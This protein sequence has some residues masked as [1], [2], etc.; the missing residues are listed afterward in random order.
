MR[1]LV[2]WFQHQVNN[3]Q[4]LILAAFLTIGFLLIVYAGKM[5]APVIAGMVVA[6]I[7]EGGVKKVQSLKVPRLGAV[8]IILSLFLLLLIALVF[9]IIPLVSSQSFQLAAQ[10]PSWLSDVQ[11]MLLQLPQIYPELLSEAQVR[12]F[13]RTTADYITE[14][15]Q[16]SVVS[17][18]SASV[19][20]FL[21]VV[22]YLIVVPILAFFFLK[23]KEKLTNWFVGILP[24]KNHDLAFT[25]WKNVDRQ[26]S[27]Y[28]RGKF[29]EILIVFFVTFITFS[30]FDLQFAAFLSVIVGLSV[31]IPI[32]GAAVVTLP[33]IV[34]AFG[35][36][37]IS[38]EFAYVVT[39]YIVIQILDG[40]VLVPLL[41]SQAVN[42]H[43]VAI[44]VALLVFGGWWGV[45]GVFFAIPLA[46]L[47]QSVM[48]AWP[49]MHDSALES[50]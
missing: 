33:V 7:L 3:P 25:V 31:L 48:T 28:I 11:K 44:V 43:P 16:Q 10:I 32:V 40:N 30:I 1:E 13:L 42:L 19:I 5:I 24:G 41:Y 21:T 34:V 45:W 36:F 49:R 12:E 9:G 18:T 14:L 4:I 23:D 29:W 22:I 17:F 35:Q 50:E 8:L 6:Y 27:N 20:G 15:G 26:M 38:P 39:A 47:V 2:N 37:G 46:T